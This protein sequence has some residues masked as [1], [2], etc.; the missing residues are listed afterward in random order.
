M[1]ISKVLIIYYDVINTNLCIEGKTLCGPKS[2]R[3]SDDLL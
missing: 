2:V 1:E 3:I